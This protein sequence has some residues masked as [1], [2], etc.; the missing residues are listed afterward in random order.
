MLLSAPV[1]WDKSSALG[2]P[3]SVRNRKKFCVWIFH[4]RVHLVYRLA[5]NG[6][7]AAGQLAVFQGF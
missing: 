1:L 3:R 4:S 7:V 6:D 5:Y 2:A